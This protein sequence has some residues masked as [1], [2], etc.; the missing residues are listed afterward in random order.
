MQTYYALVLYA[1]KNGHKY[2]DDLKTLLNYGMET[3]QGREQ[4]GR[5]GVYRRRKGESESEK[6]GREGG[7]AREGRWK[8]ETGRMLRGTADGEWP[9]EALREGSCGGR[10]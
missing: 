2:T 8:M 6:E 5:R 10:W 3:G 7:L 1:S 4:R 9:S